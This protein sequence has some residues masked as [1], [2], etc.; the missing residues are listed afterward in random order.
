MSDIPSARRWLYTN[1]DRD[2]LDDYFQMHPYTWYFT[3]WGDTSH[4]ALC[5]S[6]ALGP[7]PWTVTRRVGRFI[8]QQLTA[9]TTAFSGFV[10]PYEVQCL[11]RPQMERGYY[12]GYRW[13]FPTSRV[14]RDGILADIEASGESAAF[15]FFSLPYELRARVRDE[16]G[17]LQEMWLPSA[18]HIT[19]HAHYTQP[20][21][22]ELT[23]AAHEGLATWTVDF[24]CTNLSLFRPTNAT[25]LAQV[26]SRW[27]Q[28]LE[29]HPDRWP[30][31]AEEDDAEES[32]ADSIDRDVLTLAEPPTGTPLDNSELSEQN[33]PR[34]QDAVARW[35]AEIGHTF[36]WAV[37]S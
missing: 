15:T 31:T 10:E 14:E 5:G 16:H 12:S 13:P 32:D 23:S 17:E 2:W 19:Y 4:W 37:M 33:L 6:V 11:F 3:Q 24:H 20:G 35:Q 27:K 18:G 21:S 30:S 9:L 7:A 36:D 22:Y 25:V 8:M 28:W 34:L 26:R 29:E 1:A